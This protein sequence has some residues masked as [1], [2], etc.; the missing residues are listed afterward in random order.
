MHPNLIQE[1]KTI[2]TIL[3]NLNFT[4]IRQNDPIWIKELNPITVMWNRKETKPISTNNP[5][6]ISDNHHSFA[7]PRDE[8]YLW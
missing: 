3:L 6:P 2:T 7:N 4:Q 8:A 5:K 1:I